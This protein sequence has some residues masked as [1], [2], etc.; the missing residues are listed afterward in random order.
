MLKNKINITLPS[1][2][3]TEL[4]QR[5]NLKIKKKKEEIKIK[6]ED[7]KKEK[8]DVKKTFRNSFLNILDYFPNLDTKQKEE[9]IKF[10]EFN[11][12]KELD[13]SIHKEEYI[14]DEKLSRIDEAENT[15]FREDEDE[16]DNLNLIK[17]ID[18]KNK[19]LRLFRTD[20]DYNKRRKSVLAVQGNQNSEYFKNLEKSGVPHQRGNKFA[21]AQLI[22]NQNTF[23]KEHKTQRWKMIYKSKSIEKNIYKLPYLEK[24]ILSLDEMNNKNN[25]EFY[26]LKEKSNNFSKFKGK[27]WKNP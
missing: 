5:N 10:D 15:I 9:N 25:P 14:N 17:P 13:I 23:K 12:I 22:H 8:R 19:Y 27:N 2:N 24:S 3:M 4:F 26:L 21:R 1:Q 20:N 7:K 11:D 18:V 6:I 16:L